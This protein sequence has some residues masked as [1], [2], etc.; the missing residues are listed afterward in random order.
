M[1]NEKE[2]KEQA[3]SIKR[4]V[5]L[6]LLVLLTT[7]GIITTKTEPK[8]VATVSEVTDSTVAVEKTVKARIDISTPM[9]DENKSQFEVFVNGSEESEKQVNWMRNLQRDG[10]VIKGEGSAMEILIKARNNADLV[11]VL[12]GPDTRDKNGNRYPTWVKYTS[13]IINGEELLSEPANVW[14]DKPFIYTL[15]TKAGKEYKIH[16]KWTKRTEE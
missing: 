5:V 10:F 12:R 15:K 2:T 8:V 13:V 4:D 7:F 1:S 14:H 11:V 3:K 16:A 6:A 9:V